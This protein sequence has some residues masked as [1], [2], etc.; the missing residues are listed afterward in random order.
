MRGVRRIQVASQRIS[1]VAF[2]EVASR[3]FGKILLNERPLTGARLT[4]LNNKTG[5]TSTDEVNALGE[6]R[7]DLDEPGTYRARLSLGSAPLLG[8]ERTLEVHRG[9]N[10]VNWNITGGTLEVNITGWDR[11]TPVSIDLGRVQTS[12]QER[13]PSGLQFTAFPVQPLDQL[14]LAIVG[15]A[16]GAY[17]VSA[18]QYEGSTSL[19]RPRRV[20]TAEQVSIGAKEPKRSVTLKLEDFKLRVLLF[21]QGQRPVAGASVNSPSRT[22][23]EEQVGQ[24]RADGIAPGTFLNIAAPKFAP[25][26]VL[27]T[28]SEQRV[29]LAAGRP[30]E[31]RFVGF[32][33]TEPPGSLRWSGSSCPVRLTRFSY[34]LIS[35]DESGSR[36]RIADFPSQAAVTFEATF[37][38]R[39]IGVTLPLT[40]PSS[41]VIE[42]II[43]SGWPLELANYR[44]RR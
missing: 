8:Q 25:L 16:D 38:G 44:S 4:L 32:S 29:T 43:P 33:A 2:D 19:G 36:F 39:G 22:L 6:F 7:M 17:K 1:E 28:E 10:E 31:L 9:S 30:V 12:P 34:S 15:L 37:P 40:V 3:V 41:G 42:I 24:F 23:F 26:C 13:L 20:S 35:A 27:A 18:S 14:P 5:S 11:S 21:D